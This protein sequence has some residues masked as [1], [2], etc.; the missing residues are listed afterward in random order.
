MS[1]AAQIVENLRALRS[2]PRTESEWAALRGD[3]V[4]VYRGRRLTY[5]ANACSVVG[6]GIEQTQVPCVTEIVLG[7]L[8]RD[9]LG[10]QHVIGIDQHCRSIVTAARIAPLYVERIERSLRFEITSNE[11]ELALREQ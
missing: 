3:P 5:P 8:L 9:V 1:P 11:L 10:R 2:D 7:T 4:V 6:G